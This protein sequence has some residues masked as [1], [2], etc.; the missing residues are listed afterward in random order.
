MT[1]ALQGVYK[2]K[3]FSFNY[4]A[5]WAIF[6]L[7]PF[8]IDTFGGKYENGGVIPAG[9]AEIDIVTT[10]AS[11]L[12][13]DIIDTELMYAKNLTA[14]TV[15]VDGVSC[16]KEVYEADYAPSASSKDVALYCSRGSELWKIYLSYGASDSA[17]QTHLS[18][19]NGILSSMKL[20]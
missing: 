20:L 12:V 5:S 15:S 19:L 9:G 11:G 16:K 2:G 10:T 18:D 4:P 17:E 1:V 6:S 7:A 13:Q 14:S 8:S 3:S